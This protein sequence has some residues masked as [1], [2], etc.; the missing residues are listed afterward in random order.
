MRA[1]AI[2]I[3]TSGIAHDFNKLLAQIE[4]HVTEGLGALQTG[5]P[6]TIGHLEHARADT[7]AARKLV[8][9]LATLIRKGSPL[10]ETAAPGKIIRETAHFCTKGSTV[11]CTFNLPDNLWPARIDAISL[12]Q[13]IQGIV[14]RATQAMPEGGTIALRAENITLPPD[15]DLPIQ[16]GHHIRIAIADTGPAIAPDKLP[17]IFTPPHPGEH[18]PDRPGLAASFSIARDHGGHI[19][20]TSSPGA[21]THM[22]MYLPAHA[23][24]SHARLLSDQKSASIAKQSGR[25]LIMDD[26]ESMRQLLTHGLTRLGYETDQAANGDDAIALYRQ[27]MQSAKPFSAVI[28]DLVIPEGMDGK[29][30]LDQLV[31]L[32]P[33]VKAV[34]CSGLI[35][36]PCLTHYREHGF[37]AALPKPFSL[38]T[39][40]ATMSHLIPSHTTPPE[41]PHT[42]P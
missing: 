10:K 8:R 18:I 7:R 5:N 41:Q 16:P 23:K 32:N 37:T 9:Q 15:A 39:L 36:S 21:G 33:D 3:L 25:I 34:V 2:E 6:A 17:R 19:T 29:A 40:A 26:D 22:E 14:A 1:A 31:K 24:A 30:T 27:A 20:A 35:S 28:L 12:S 42:H 11:H 38:R 4:S 13:A